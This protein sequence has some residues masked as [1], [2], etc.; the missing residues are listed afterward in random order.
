M[1]NE[2]T[3]AQ[4]TLAELCSSTFAARWFDQL[5]L[6][7]MGIIRPDAELGGFFADVSGTVFKL[8]HWAK[9]TARAD[10]DNGANAG[11]RRIQSYGEEAIVVRRR[12][13]YSVLQSTVDAG[14]PTAS[15]NQEIANQTPPV[16]GRELQA[17]FWDMLTALFNTATG[18]LR[19]THCNSVFKTSGTAQPATRAAF[20]NAK[21]KLG[22]A[23]SQL[24][25][26]IA[27]SSVVADLRNEW[28]DKSNG[29][30]FDMN[31]FEGCVLVE[32]DTVPTLGGGAGF[33]VYPTFAFGLGA[34]GLVMQ[35]ALT[36]RSVFNSGI[37]GDDVVQSM[38]LAPHVFGCSFTG[39]PSTPEYGPTL[40]EL[41]TSTNYTKRTGVDDK[42]IQ[43]VCLASN[44]RAR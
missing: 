27:H 31:N 12:I 44:I 39:T 2:I 11:N 28:A 37:N 25:V 36:V 20:L 19:T 41:Q 1:S 4:L 13:T 40:A 26:A 16:W 22:D 9:N 8:R 15:I 32:D 42:E 3:P 23:Q 30:P 35:R 7:R 38:A 10:Y 17:T 14:G 24:K 34:L 43:V 18:I 6:T 33:E 21:G 5:A 29:Q